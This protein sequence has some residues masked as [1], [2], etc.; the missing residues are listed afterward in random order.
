LLSAMI[1]FR[2]RWN[3]EVERRREPAPA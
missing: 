3:V 1:G 2:Q